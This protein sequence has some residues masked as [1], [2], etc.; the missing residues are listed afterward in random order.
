MLYKLLVVYI[1]FPYFPCIIKRF[2]GTKF[3][4]FRGCDSDFNTIGF[5]ALIFNVALHVGCYLASLK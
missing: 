3:S 5:N 1:P 2:F 4:P